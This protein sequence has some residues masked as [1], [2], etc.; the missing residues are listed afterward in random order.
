MTFII[1]FWISR[2]SMLLKNFFIK[3][4]RHCWCRWIIII[5]SIVSI[6]VHWLRMVMN[7]CILL[8]YHFR[9]CPFFRSIFIKVVIILHSSTF[10]KNILRRGFMH[11]YFISI[12]FIYFIFISL[13]IF[14]FIFSLYFFRIWWPTI[15]FIL[16]LI[17]K[18]VI[19][20]VSL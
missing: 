15:F 10:V 8:S 16:I 12:I 20:I 4:W 17:F 14:L 11:H 3:C 1:K 9:C 13:L 7:V 5:N 18:K 19:F 2:I 6:W